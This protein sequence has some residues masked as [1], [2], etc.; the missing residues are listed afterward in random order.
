MEAG[1]C[2]S[3]T[4]HNGTHIV[5]LAGEL[6]LATAPGLRAALGELSGPLLLDCEHLRFLD[7]SGLRVLADTARSN[8]TLTLRH[9]APDIRRVLHIARMDSLVALEERD[10]QPGR[11]V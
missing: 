2:L 10:A 1:F 5:R 9:V 8:G 11:R 6:D 7:A 4:R 3:V